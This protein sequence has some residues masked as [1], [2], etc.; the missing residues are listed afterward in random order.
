M[1]TALVGI[2]PLS[3]SEESKIMKKASVYHFFN[4]EYWVKNKRGLFYLMTAIIGASIAIY[5]ILPVFEKK[6]AYKDMI[7]AFLNADSATYCFRIDDSVVKGSGMCKQPGKVRL[8][9]GNEMRFLYDFQ[10]NKMTA[11]VRNVKLA[12]TR[13][14]E[15]E[16]LEQVNENRMDLLYIQ[17]MLRPFLADS[18]ASITYLPKTYIGQIKAIGCHFVSPKTDMKFWVN[19]E[20]LA[21]PE[22]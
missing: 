6:I 15:K 13:T 18:N 9:M 4:K 2:W 11:L 19:Y 17:D 14:L 10:T 5:F 3:I 1:L 21:P 16:Q 8:D 12:S 22:N 20:T 7:K